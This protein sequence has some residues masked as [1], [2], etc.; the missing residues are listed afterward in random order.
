MVLVRVITDFQYPGFLSQTPGGAGVWQ[1]V[2]FT[3]DPV[4]RCD[5]VVVCNRVL[6]KTPLVVPPDNVWQVAME[7]PIPELRYSRRSYR[8]FRYVFTQ[9]ASLQGERY[10]HCHGALPWNIG[11]NYDDLI[12]RTPPKKA[13]DL[14][15]ITSNKAR[16]PGHRTRLKLLAAMRGRIDFEL[17]GQGY[18]PLDK[19]WNG[20]S[21]FRYSM[22]IENYHGADYWTEKIADCYL[23]WTMPI[24]WGATNITR[25]FPAESMVLVDAEDPGTAI[26][27]IEET[28]RSD[29]F[30][31]N[32]D[33]ISYARD[34]VLD[35]HQ[36]FP[37]ITDRIHRHEP[38][39]ADNSPR[40]LIIHPAHQPALVSLFSAIRRS[41]GLRS[42]L[43][44]L[45]KRVFAGQG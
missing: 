32:I 40:P 35:K 36:F 21:P 23:C 15:W 6:A 12:G 3:L 20:L 9:D 34:L 44:R 38:R 14:S 25:Y 19:K 13:A 30:E 4:E 39:S 24:Y 42:R 27:Q 41:V 11:L 29:R 2:R 43:A 7:P 16:Y 45:R 18:R 33:A 10:I 8:Q 37:F 5:F 28:V 31:R 22:A 1:D 26:Q 17:W